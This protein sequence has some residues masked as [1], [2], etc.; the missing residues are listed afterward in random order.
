MRNI[1][2][3]LGSVIREARMVNKQTQ[4]QLAAR[5]NIS[6]HYLLSIENNRKKPS[7]D[8]LFRI[9]RELSIPADKIFYPEFAQSKAEIDELRR[10]LAQCSEKEAHLVKAALRLIAEKE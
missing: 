10:L 4:K 1:S 9:I 2:D 5:L 3:E 6:T 7:Y 8:L